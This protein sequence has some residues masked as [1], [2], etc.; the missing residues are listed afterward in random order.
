ML[1]VD[2][3][4][5]VCIIELKNEEAEESILPQAPGYAIWDETNPDS[6]KAIRLESH[7]KPEGVTPDW[8]NFD[9]RIILIAPS[10]KNAVPRMATKIGYSVDLVRSFSTT[11]Y[12]IVTSTIRP[13]STMGLGHIAALKE[14]YSEAFPLPDRLVAHM[15]EEDSP[16]GGFFARM[17]RGPLWA[18]PGNM[19]KGSQDF[20]RITEITEQLGNGEMKAIAG[21]TGARAFFDREEPDLSRDCF[22]GPKAFYAQYDSGHD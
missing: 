10:F 9:S 2:K 22:K 3:V 18:W 8:D 1:G 7:K 14:D 11:R 6:I 20:D 19:R 21:E 5:R 17:S 4:N 13:L 16:G 15:E 12:S